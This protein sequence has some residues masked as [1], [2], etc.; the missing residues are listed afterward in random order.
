MTPRS[1]VDDAVTS[2]P[3]RPY[4]AL[5][6]ELF[7]GSQVARPNPYDGPAGAERRLMLAVL[8]DAIHCLREH[9]GVMGARS[10]R[11]YAD[12]RRWLASEDE[13]SPFGFR[14]IC[15][16]LELDAG[17][18]RRHL[19]TPALVVLSGRSPATAGRSRRP[20]MTPFGGARR[21]RA[22]SR[23]ARRTR[24]AG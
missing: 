6:P 16:V 7:L 3:D 17:S 9:V 8:E 20:R 18:V 22:G 13:Q 24:A 10:L 1:L 4:E 19:R 5:A 15:E 2:R 12:A 21:P 14:R 11:L 23:A